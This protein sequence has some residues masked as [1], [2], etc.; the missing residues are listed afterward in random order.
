V[1]NVT[2]LGLVTFVG[3]LTEPGYAWV[4]I[5]HNQTNGWLRFIKKARH[6]GFFG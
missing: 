3:G 1:E 5:K 6:D 4:T 2:S